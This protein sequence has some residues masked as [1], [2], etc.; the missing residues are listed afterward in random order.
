MVAARIR[1]R[2]KKYNKGKEG[3]G[4]RV[5]NKMLTDSDKSACGVQFVL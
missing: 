4:V 2:C 1:T 3:Q 5:K